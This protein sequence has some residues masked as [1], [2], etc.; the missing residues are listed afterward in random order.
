MNAV[1]DPIAIPDAISMSVEFSGRD[2]IVSWF[3][4]EIGVLFCTPNVEVR[5]VF[6]IES[7]ANVVSTKSKIGIYYTDTISKIG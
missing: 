3:G 2:D 7:G 6:V 4:N 5:Y 1:K